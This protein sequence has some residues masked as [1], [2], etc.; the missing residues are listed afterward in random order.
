MESV[1]IESGLLEVKN[2]SSKLSL[3][4]VFYFFSNIFCLDLMGKL[5]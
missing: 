5:N 1:Q 2:L 3:R 4:N